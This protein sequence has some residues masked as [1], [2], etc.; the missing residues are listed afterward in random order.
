[1]TDGLAEAHEPIFDHGGKY[2]YFLASTDAGPA[3]NWF[4]QS[5]TD[6]QPTTSL[7]LVTLARATANPLL[8]ESDE[9]GTSEAADGKATKIADSTIADSKDKK[10]PDS[11]EKTGDKE[12]PVVIDLDK[13]EGLLGLDAEGQRRFVSLRRD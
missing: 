2:L 3:N 11:K 12:K 9:E 13:V 4:D 8:K 5:F 10:E 1:M 6:M 7:Y